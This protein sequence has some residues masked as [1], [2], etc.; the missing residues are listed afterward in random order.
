MLPDLLERSILEVAELLKK[1]ALSPV[2][3]L[4]T[5]L[6]QI[7]AKESEI[8][9]F[10]TV[11]ADLA[12]KQAA[13]A[14]KEILRGQYKGPLHGIPISIKDSIYTKGIRTTNGAKIDKDFV[15]DFDAKIVERLTRRGAV[16]IGKA[17]L[18]E[19]AKGI[20]N[21][22]HYYGFARNPLNPHHT[23]GG[24]SGGSAA[25]VAAGMAFASVGTDTGGSI[26]IPASCCALV[27]LK[28]T[29][30]LVASHG[31]TPLSSS[32]DHIGPIAKTAKDAELLLL[33]MLDRESVQAMGGRLI[34]EN[35]DFKNIVAGVPS[36]FCFE[37]IAP[38]VER[39]I[40]SAI[41]RIQQL[42]GTVEEITL[43]RLDRAMEVYRI[44]GNVEA[45]AFHQE[46]MRRQLHDFDPEVAHL[47]KLGE[48]FTGT[49]Y[50]R[51]QH[52]RQ[53]IHDE[54][55]K[56]FAR[57]DILLTPTLTVLPPPVGTTNV[58]IGEQEQPLLHAFI[59]FTSPFN[60]T[61][62][63]AASI[64][65]AKNKDNLP[66]GLQIIANHRREADIL[67]VAHRYMREFPV[68]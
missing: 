34:D 7:E 11:T 35:F 46:R 66:S 19:Y 61:G 36:H 56:A 3:L 44:M 50:V 20:T 63:P 5:T 1:K 33:G 4:Q 32:F 10:I 28:P 14:E 37:Q 22:N 23:P 65:V 64:P 16:I 17:N 60:V 15:P 18:H 49:E 6:K 26:R 42:G 67:N 39:N 58:K 43:P 40:K 48:T 38:E 12:E 13:A 55:K 2:E 47:L 54:I 53:A 25:S 9:A 45:A 52:M 8:N 68:H 57:V 59:R 31:V 51:A 62:F 29:Y 27:G 30:G 21:E 41:D 24:S